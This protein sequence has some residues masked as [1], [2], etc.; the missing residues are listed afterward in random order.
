MGRTP[1][2]GSRAWLSKQREY[3]QTNIVPKTIYLKGDAFV[4]EKAHVNNIIDLTHDN[5]TTITYTL[6]PGI[7]EPGES[8]EIA[9]GDNGVVEIYIAASGCQWSP[10]PTENPFW[11]ISVPGRSVVITRQRHEDPENTDEV[12]FIRGSYE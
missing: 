4:L 6:H 8:V 12:M 2:F 3:V 10:E 1:N 5:A 11:M 9:R 7:L